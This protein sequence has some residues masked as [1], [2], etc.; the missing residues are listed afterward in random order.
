[1]FARNICVV[2]SF[3]ILLLSCS[4]GTSPINYEDSNLAVTGMVVDENGRPI[5]DAGIHYMPQLVKETKSLSK[6]NPSTKI[7]FSIPSDSSIVSL[8]ILRY[9]SRDTLAV[10]LE[11]EIL[12]GGSYSND[13][14]QLPNGIFL[15]VIVINGI[16]TEKLTLNIILDSSDLEV[17]LPLTKS[18]I[19]GNFSFPSKI[20]GIGEK[21]IHT[22]EYGNVT[23]S[24]IISSEFE[25]IATKEGYYPSSETINL[26]ERGKTFKRIVLKKK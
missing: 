14:V 17:A 11:N 21:F 20:L 16:T 18:D 9:G 2:L 12:N 23:N 3:V 1:M 22:D 25:I 19:Y 26:A 13:T 24:E 6:P 8:Y 10:L 4:D 7:S 5:E 15:Y